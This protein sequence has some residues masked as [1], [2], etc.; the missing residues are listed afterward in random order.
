MSKETMK[1]Q[2]SSIITE[3]EMLRGELGSWLNDY[4]KAFITRTTPESEVFERLGKDGKKRRYV[5]SSYVEKVL[6]LMF[7]FKWN[8]EIKS[9]FTSPCGKK[10]IT[11]G[12]L[13]IKSSDLYEPIIKEQ[14]GSAEYEGDWGDTYKA[15]LA[16][17]TK[18]CATK[19]GLFSDIY[20]SDDLMKE[21]QSESADKLTRINDLIKEI[22]DLQIEPSKT[23]QTFL[24]RVVNSKEHGS[25]DKAITLLE[26]KLP[27]Q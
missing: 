19:L 21:Q 1:E 11:I 18:K 5:K 20:G 22:N 25:Y 9:Q 3:E 15:S 12:R 8:I 14:V 7:D 6:N 23:E 26:S 13:T 17:C 27:K 2:P 10:V 4:Q 16:D 24:K